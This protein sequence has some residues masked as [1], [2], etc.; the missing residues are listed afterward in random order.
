MS[1][2]FILLTINDQTKAFFKEKGEKGHI[3]V[4][5]RTIRVM[6]LQEKYEKSKWGK[7]NNPVDFLVFEEGALKLGTRWE[8]R[9][10]T[11]CPNSISKKI[12]PVIREYIS[13]IYRIDE[14]YDPTTI[15]EVANFHM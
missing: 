13:R 15:F 2:G 3:E 6:D 1:L 9:V 12:Y 7:M 14:V 4:A 8:D 11:Y 5:L 10:L